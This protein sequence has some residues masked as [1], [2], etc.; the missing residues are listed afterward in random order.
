MSIACSSDSHSSTPCN[1]IISMIMSRGILGLDSYFSGTSK[2]FLISSPPKDGGA[3]VH[4]PARDV[5]PRQC[6]RASK[7]SGMPCS[8]AIEITPLWPSGLEQPFH[9]RPHT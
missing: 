5:T 2:Q 4:F 6:Y 1:I 8:N 3:A 7:P 9:R